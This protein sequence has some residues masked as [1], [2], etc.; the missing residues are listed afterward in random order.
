MT[1]VDEGALPTVKFLLEEEY[2]TTAHQNCKG[3]TPM[4]QA[5]LKR[6]SAVAKLLRSSDEQTQVLTL[7]T[8][9]G[10]SCLHYAARYFTPE[11]LHCLLRFYQRHEGVGGEGRA[12][13]NSANSAGTTALFLVATSA[14]D[15]L[16]DRNAKTRLMFRADA[17]LLGSHP[18]F[19][20]APKEDL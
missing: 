18:F 19:E 14:S 5:I 3:E 6:K 17:K 9:S 12:L 16:D 7:N 2:A 11:E 1:A 13:W 8:T 20:T 15:S 10:E 4:H